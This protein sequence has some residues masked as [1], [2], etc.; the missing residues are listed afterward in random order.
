MFRIDMDIF[1]P[2]I[3]PEITSRYQP[4]ADNWLLARRHCQRHRYQPVVN[5]K[6]EI[7][8]EV[9]TVTF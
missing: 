8:T 1:A 6:V 5:G 7:Q 4:G 2:V 3:K 9:Q